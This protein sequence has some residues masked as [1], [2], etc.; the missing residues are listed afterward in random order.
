MAI[1]TIPKIP[2]L[3]SLADVIGR[4]VLQMNN[5]GPKEL[6]NTSL[7]TDFEVSTNGQAELIP[8]PDAAGDGYSVEN[9]EIIP[10][11]TKAVTLRAAI[12]IYKTGGAEDD[13]RIWLMDDQ[14]TITGDTV[15][16]FFTDV[17]KYSN[18]ERY[19]APVPLTAGRKYGFYMQ[20]DSGQNIGIVTVPVSGVAPAIPSFSLVI[21][22]L[23]TADN[24]V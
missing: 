15:L 6:L 14:G 9:G 2:I 10:E 1:F 22:T 19:S 24:P 7:L 8:I 5:L 3:G 4:L 20:R 18:I 13:M 11:K 17:N 12:N 16:R 21:H 23:Q